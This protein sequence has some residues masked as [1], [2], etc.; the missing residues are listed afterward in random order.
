[1]LTIKSLAA[2]LSVKPSTLYSWVA[3]GKI[4]VLKINGVIRFEERDIEQWLQKC[5]VS[6]GP[7]REMAKYRCRGPVTSVHHLIERAKRAVY[8]SRGETSDSERVRKGGAN[9]AR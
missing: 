2:Q 6:V 7:P 8:T 4:P 5:R 9:G 3:Q 1:M